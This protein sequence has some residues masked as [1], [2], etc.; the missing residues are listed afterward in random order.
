MSAPEE[1]SP[2][3]ASLEAAAEWYAR[4]RDER[5]SAAEH[6][7]WRAWLEQAPEHRRAWQWMEQVAE[8]LDGL[9][10][11]VRA[12]DAGEVLASARR[13][14]VSR[15]RM[16]RGLGA[17]AVLGPLG[18]AAW[19]HTPLPVYARRA[20]TDYSTAVG[21]IRPVTLADGSGLW[22]NT[23]SAVN[24]TFDADSRRLELVSGEILVDTVA[25][26]RPFLVG[27]ARGRLQALGTE[28]AARHRADADVVQVFRGAVA[29]RPRDV[30]GE[31]VI[32][33]GR[34]ARFSSRG[35]RAVDPLPQS[36]A[37]WRDGVVLADHRPLGDLVAEL[38]RYR[39]GYLGVDPRVADLPVMGAYPLDDTDRALDLLAEA[40]PVRVSR[41]LPWWVTVEPA[42]AP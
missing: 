22:L 19:R 29:L 39:P 23:A 20:W 35:V 5:V 28:F 38:A 11:A 4:L 37:H 31:R 17:L 26:T 3:R 36:A 25:E 34:Q 33:A 8:R 24:V 27:T 21:E 41:R 7:R 2:D 14:R 13:R 32:P 10:E 30:H 40:L 12:G 18:L 16:L 9:G 1:P 42:A 6:G 15:R